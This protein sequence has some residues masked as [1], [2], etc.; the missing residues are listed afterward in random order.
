M[1]VCVQRGN[2]GNTQGM[3]L[4]DWN[5]FCCRKHTRS[6]EFSS[7]KWIAAIW[8]TKSECKGKQFTQTYISILLDYWTLLF[9][10]TEWLCV[11]F[12]AH[13]WMIF[14]E[15]FMCLFLHLIMCCVFF[16][17]HFFEWCNL[18]TQTSRLIA[19]SECRSCRITRTGIKRTRSVS[20]A[21]LRWNHFWTLQFRQFVLTGLHFTWLIA[22]NLNDS[23]Q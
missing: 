8:C 11:F 15:Y 13:M 12:K 22:F 6:K 14:T 5:E 17:F 21:F 2:E 20:L 9:T 16:F 1:S 10:K 23:G 3:C 4:A 18:Y 19:I 7:L